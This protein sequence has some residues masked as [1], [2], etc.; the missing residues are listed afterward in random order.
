MA[1]AAPDWVVRLLMSVEKEHAQQLEQ[2]ERDLA[3]L[4]ESK[5]SIESSYQGM[6]KDWEARCEQ[7]EK[8]LEQ[9]REKTRS[10]EESYRSIQ[11]VCK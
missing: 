7:L 6:L 1:D 11:E 8:G 5:E 2:K 9:E 10:W 3:Q 4:Q